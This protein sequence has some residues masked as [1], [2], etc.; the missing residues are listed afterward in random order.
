MNKQSQIN[1][2]NKYLAWLDRTFPGAK[3]KIT[4]RLK[5]GNG[6][7]AASNLFSTDFVP[8]VWEGSVPFGYPVSPTQGS[9]VPGSAIA[10]PVANDNWLTSTI[11]SIT[12][13]A[14][15]ILP[16]YANWDMQKDAYKIQMERAKQGKE[17]LDMSRYAPAVKLQHGIDLRNT[18][19]Q[20]TKNNLMI[21]AGILA[22]IFLLPR[23]LK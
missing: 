16:A 20:K 14:N 19:D 13:M 11:E 17:P 22:S 2:V 9:Y 10:T 12:S 3:E 23:L 7:G 8:S 4:S 6:L 1:I 15:E 5:M 21:G 18:F